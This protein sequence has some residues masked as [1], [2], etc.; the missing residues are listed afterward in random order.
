MNCASIILGIIGAPDIKNYAGIVGTLYRSGGH[1]EQC[2]LAISFDQ[3]HCSLIPNNK[4]LM[5]TAR[6]VFRGLHTAFSNAR[7]QPLGKARILFMPICV[8]SS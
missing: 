4:F 7:I 5:F 2:K 8:K 3:V 1:A 6:I